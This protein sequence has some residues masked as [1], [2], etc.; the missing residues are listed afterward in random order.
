MYLQISL[1]S[2]FNEIGQ[3]SVFYNFIQPRFI[4]FPFTLT[5]CSISVIM[6]SSLIPKNANNGQNSSMFYFLSALFSDN[7]HLPLKIAGAIR[8]FTA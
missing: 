7:S 2:I 6:T 4:S 8:D 5:F 1:S 3:L